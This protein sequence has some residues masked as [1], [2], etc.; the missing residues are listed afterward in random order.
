MMYQ[1]RWKI[2]SDEARATA[3]GVF[4]YLRRKEDGR[5]VVQ[6]ML[7]VGININLSLLG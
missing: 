6:S 3:R 2:A 7:A 4:C 1:S 5:F